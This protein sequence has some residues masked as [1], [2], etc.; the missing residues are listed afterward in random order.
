MV[1]GE[2]KSSLISLLLFVLR[3]LALVSSANL[4]RHV[5]FVLFFNTESQS[6]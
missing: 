5:L 1:S 6:V 4:Q 2:L 3:E